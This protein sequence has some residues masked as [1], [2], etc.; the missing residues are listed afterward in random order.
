MSLLQN[1]KSPNF[2]SEDILNQLFSFSED[3]EIICNLRKGIAELGLIQ[4]YNVC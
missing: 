3:N 2:M 1:G 4:V